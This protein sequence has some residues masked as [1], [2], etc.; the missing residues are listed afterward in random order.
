MGTPDG[1]KCRLQSL[2]GQFRWG[3]PLENATCHLKPNSSENAGS[4]FRV[5]HCH[6]MPL[7]NRL[8]NLGFG[9]DFALVVLPL[10][11]LPSLSGLLLE[12]DDSTCFRAVASGC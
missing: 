6:I 12:R 4:Q 9:L 2:V 11:Y 3:D 1:P 8:G 10:A 5:L 7:G